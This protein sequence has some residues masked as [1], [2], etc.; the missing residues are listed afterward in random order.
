VRYLE[1][2]NLKLVVDALKERGI[3]MK[4]AANLVFKLAFIIPT[5]NLWQKIYYGFGLKLYDML[6]GSLSL[7]KT[8]ILS[9]KEVENILPNLNQSN[10]TGGVL[11]YDGQFDDA[12]L[13][14]HLAL[15][16][17]NFG[18]CVLNYFSVTSFIK[19]NK[20]ITGV[21]AKDVLS[22]KDYKIST[23]V[24]VNA[25][26]VFSEEIIK[27]D[28]QN[29][30]TEISPSQGIHLV[31][32]RKFLKSDNAIMIPK[33]KDGRVL[34]AVPWYNVVI[35]GTTDTPI[36]NV[37]YEPQALKE[38]IDFILEHASIYLNN[39]PTYEDVKSVYVGL[40]PLV[41]SKNKITSAV[42][43]DHKISISE[44]GLISVIGGKWTTY[45]KM[46][47]DVLKFIDNSF[48][49]GLKNCKTKEIRLYQYTSHENIHASMLHPN[50][51]YTHQDIINAVNYEMCVT[52]EDALARRTRFLFLDANIAKE[53]APTVANL[54]AKVMGKD[55]E[56][57]NN[58]LSQFYSLADNY[59][60]PQHQTFH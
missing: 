10:I 57:I 19:E 26:G 22:N 51:H 16:A 15:T 7:G 31:I 4:N 45:R 34:F 41:K 27:I 14:I 43:R 28:N 25:T 54:M 40:R 39:K 8:Q 29:A 13:S 52:L 32:D 24:V 17:S 20:K 59:L 6:S 46:A 18:A 49:L 42:S 11:Y 50:Y 58:Q 3:L 48:K 9:R 38:E 1:Q 2:G 12:R 55:Q 60:I 33:T 21:I 56:W 23:K 35:L 44:S 5:Y 37:C 47:E 30:Q 36:S 53:V